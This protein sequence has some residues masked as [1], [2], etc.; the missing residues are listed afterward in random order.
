M[1]PS[2]VHLTA[3]ERRVLAEALR[4]LYFKMMLGPGH[5]P[6]IVSETLRK[7]EGR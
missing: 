4:A 5:L 1:K 6:I 3:D 7:L 2:Y